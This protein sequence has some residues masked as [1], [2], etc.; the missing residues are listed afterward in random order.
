MRAAINGTEWFYTAQGKGETILFLHGGLDTAANYERLCASLADAY[1]VVSVDR[2]G[3][4]RTADTD[5]PFDYTLMA[6]E[7]R[8]FIAAL[9]LGAV[10][11]LGYS[12]GANIGLHLA[13]AFPETV[14]SLVAISG[15]YKGLSGMSEQWL[16]ALPKLSLEYAREHMGMAL[17]Q[18]MDLNPAP[19]PAAYIAKTR[20]LWCKDAAVPEEKLAAIRTA[21]LIIAGDRDI[22]LPEQ[23]LAMHALIPQ[24]SL[25][26]LP[27][28]GHCIFQDFIWNAPAEAAIIMI[29]DFLARRSAA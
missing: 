13:S 18:Y 1:R 29:R 25:M 2:R 26:L 28:A 6:A 19:D 14:K 15:N 17:R 20:A 11:L 5:A 7:T 27:R 22:V 9:D 12:D 3:H 4:G 8:A 23:S 10:H 21:T 24:S 16:D